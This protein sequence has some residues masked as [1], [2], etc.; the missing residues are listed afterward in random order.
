VDF[1]TAIVSRVVLGVTV[2][3]KVG[4]PVIVMEFVVVRLNCLPNQLMEMLVLPVMKI[5]LQASNVNHIPFV[6]FHWFGEWR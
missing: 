6:T 4:I 5:V 2:I 3:I 1:P